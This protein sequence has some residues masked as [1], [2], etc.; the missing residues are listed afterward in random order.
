MG[1]RFSHVGKIAVGLIV[2]LQNGQEM[3]IALLDPQ[4]PAV[5][6]KRLVRVG[7]L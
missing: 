7:F 1:V 4:E 2:F 5:H 3:G 6:V